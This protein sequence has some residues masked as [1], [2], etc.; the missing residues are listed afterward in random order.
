MCTCGARLPED[1]RFCHKCGKPQYDYSAIEPEIAAEPVIAAPTAAPDAPAEISFRNRTAVRI[2]FLAALIAFIVVL[3]TMPLLFPSFLIGFLAAGFFAVY[4]YTRRTGQRLSARSGARMGWM[5]GIFL[6][7]IMLVQLTAS[8]LVAPTQPGFKAA[9][10]AQMEKQGAANP[11]VQKVLPEVLKALDSPAAL[12]TMLL[13]ALFAL[14]LILT[15]LPTL[16]GALGAKLLA[17]ERGA[18]V[19]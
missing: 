3:V 19:G 4:L 5:T 16:G 6:F 13:M 2:G 10:R 15:I 9:M 12:P 18:G 1:A 17:R 11:D 14:F 7:T 8:V